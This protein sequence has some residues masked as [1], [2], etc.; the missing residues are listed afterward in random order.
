[1]LSSRADAIQGKLMGDEQSISTRSGESP[2]VSAAP[3]NVS[4]SEG[5]L[6][7]EERVLAVMCH[8]G[9]LLTRFV[10]PLVLWRKAKQRSP[11]LA[12][13]AREALNFQLFI[14]IPWVLCLGGLV[15]L[16]VVVFT[17]DLSPEA[18]IVSCVVLLVSLVVL[19]LY[20]V[21]LVLLSSLAAWRGRPP[22]RPWIIRFIR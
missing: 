6:D 3:A 4:T 5:S 15:V 14:L 20:E 12:E 22:R 18:V 17:R 10:T 16:L 2:R 8:V 11:F 13:H 9:G 19:V 1:V 7:E 21:V